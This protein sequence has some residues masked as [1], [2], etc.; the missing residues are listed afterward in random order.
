[1]NEALDVAIIG[2]GT[3]GLSAL[4]EVRRR[5]Q[6]CPYCTEASFGRDPLRISSRRSGCFPERRAAER[7]RSPARARCRPG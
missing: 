3:A 2:A 7:I 1:M 4:R 6:R 5:T